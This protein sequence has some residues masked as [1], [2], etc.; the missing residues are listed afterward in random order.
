[1]CHVLHHPKAVRWYII[2]RVKKINTS[3]QYQHKKLWFALRFLKVLISIWNSNW[4]PV[5]TACKLCCPAPTRELA[6]WKPRNNSGEFMKGNVWGKSFLP[7]SP[8]SKV[9]S[10]IQVLCPSGRHKEALKLISIVNGN[11]F[12]IY[13]SPLGNCE[14]HSMSWATVLLYLLLPQPTQN[15]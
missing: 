11:C 1:M 14:S 8:F 9:S 2:K 4:A 3:P 5:S 6:Q 10:H 13:T 7:V 12:Y 15:T